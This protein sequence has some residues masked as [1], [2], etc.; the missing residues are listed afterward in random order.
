MSQ[1]GTATTKPRREN[2]RPAPPPPDSVSATSDS[3]QSQKGRRRRSGSRGR[4][5]ENASPNG[6]SIAPSPNMPRCS[7]DITSSAIRRG[8]VEIQGKGEGR[9]S[10][11]MEEPPRVSINSSRPPTLL[12]RGSNM[13]KKKLEKAERLSEREKI[14]RRGALE[15]KKAAL[16]AKLDEVN[17]LL[18]ALG[19]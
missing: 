16:E 17:A 8:S 14:S 19:V 2:P 13:M 18:S 5:Q 12:G 7:M 6:P 4:L 15:R 10:L 1:V 9:W 11:V 3:F